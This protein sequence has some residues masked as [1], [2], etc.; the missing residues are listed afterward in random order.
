MFERIV[1]CPECKTQ[2]T[3]S[4][5]DYSPNPQGWWFTCG[6]CKSLSVFPKEIRIVLGGTY[7]S[8]LILAALIAQYS[9]W[10]VTAIALLTT[11]FVVALL[12]QNRATLV[13][14]H[15]PSW[16][17][18]MKDFL[19]IASVPLALLMAYLVISKLSGH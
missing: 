14:F 18:R 15:L 5:F 17:R 3:L 8:C 9:H 12:G 1:Y 4:T 7:F 6:T 19:D 11:P 16:S 2:R 13:P 10:L